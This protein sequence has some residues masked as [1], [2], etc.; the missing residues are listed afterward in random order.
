MKNL[1][2]DN[3]FYYQ[4]K[5]LTYLV[6]VNCRVSIWVPLKS[7]NALTPLRTGWSCLWSGACTMCFMSVFWKSGTDVGPWSQI[8]L[9]LMINKNG[10][11]RKLFPTVREVEILNIWCAGLVLTATM[12]SGFRKVNLIMP[13]KC[14]PRIRHGKSEDRLYFLV[15]RYVVKIGSDK[16]LGFYI[17]IW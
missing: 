12:I 4:V 13:V 17:L 2:W 9:L 14:L 15:G 7:W 16:N 3:L 11:L 10:K 5:I 1:K 6:R 8:Q